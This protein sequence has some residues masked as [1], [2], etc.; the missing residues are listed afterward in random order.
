MQEREKETSYTVMDTRAYRLDTL[1]RKRSTL[2]VYHPTMFIK[3]FVKLNMKSLDKYDP[4]NAAKYEWQEFNET[5]Q[6]QFNEV[7]KAADI[8]KE[9]F[10]AGDWEKAKDY[11]IVLGEMLK[12]YNFIEFHLIVWSEWGNIT[13]KGRELLSKNIK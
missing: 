10:I 2:S 4:M 9:L 13:D 5:E 6:S 3:K 11:N 1:L 8:Q 12:K 7:K